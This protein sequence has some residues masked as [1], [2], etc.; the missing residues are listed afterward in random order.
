MYIDFV[1]STAFRYAQ[2]CH[3]YILTGIIG[4][5]KQVSPSFIQ[6]FTDIHVDF[7]KW[8]RN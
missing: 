6:K 4:G 8:P 2:F 1:Y 5:W 3:I 7:L